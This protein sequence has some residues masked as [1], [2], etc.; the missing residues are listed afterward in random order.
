M[1]E[2]Y[3]AAGSRAEA[4]ERI[5]LIA[6]EL[7]RRSSTEHLKA[8]ASALR[9]RVTARVKSKAT[10]TTD[11]LKARAREAASERA[12]TLKEQVMAKPV[13]LAIAGSVA[14]ALVGAFL[15]RR[16]EAAQH[17]VKAETL[18]TGTVQPPNRE[19]S[20]DIAESFGEPVEEGGFDRATEEAGA[21][22]RLSEA[23]DHGKERLSE[24]M[25][26]AR[27]KASSIKDRAQALRHR[28][29]ERIADRAPKVGDL[30]GK[31]SGFVHDEPELLAFGALAA[32]ACLGLLF[33]LTQAERRA[34]RPLHERAREG[35]Q[36]GFERAEEALDGRATEASDLRQGREANEDIEVERHGAE[37]LEPPAL[38]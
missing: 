8:E 9:A 28:A 3:V 26:H 5:R 33:P 21:K 12:H 36:T 34:M 11:A 14:G 20:A 23:V 22:E 13:A 15:G 35:I 6:E 29:S 2:G 18:S 19:L 30:R 38:H 7:A 10:E 4:R 27:Q 31:A 16:S 17:Y 1:A 25:G 24:A 32:G 37:G